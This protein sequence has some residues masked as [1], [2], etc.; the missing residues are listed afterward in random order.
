MSDLC[1]I[2][3]EQTTHKL[4]CLHHSCVDCLKLLVKKSNL[5]PICRRVFD[6]DLYKYKPPKHTPSLKLSV[7]QKKF[8]NK[9]LS[10]R[11]LLVTSKHQKFYAHLQVVHHKYLYILGKYVSPDTMYSL[12]KLEA[13]HYYLYFSNHKCIFSQQIRNFFKLAIEEYLCLY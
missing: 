7:K 4:E 2:C 5:C 1:C 8:F 10:N 11:Y 12:N 3:L 13:L 9:F 6:T